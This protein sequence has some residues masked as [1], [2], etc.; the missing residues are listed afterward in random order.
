MFTELSNEPFFWI[1]VML[2]AVAAVLAMTERYD[3]GSD[4]SGAVLGSERYPVIYRQPMP[5]AGRT[6]AHRTASPEVGKGVLPF[7]L[8]QRAWQFCFASTAPVIINGSKSGTFR[9]ELAA[10]G[11]VVLAIGLVPM[12]IC[13]AFLVFALGI[14][15]SAECPGMFQVG[16][17]PAAHIL[18][19]LLAVTGNINS[20][21]STEF[22][23]V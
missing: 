12:A 5:E 19:R 7:I 11:V 2:A 6:T 4:R 18:G 8:G 1:A 21:F 15:L 3:V 23:S 13:R 9:K 10:I 20:A 14:V 17:P 22:F 16:K